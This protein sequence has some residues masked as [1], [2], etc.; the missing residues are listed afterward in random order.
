ML[1]LKLD[2]PHLQLS[3]VAIKILRRYFLGT[4][5]GCVHV[6]EGEL[7]RLKSLPPSQC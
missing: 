4:G 6:V 1:F 3:G 7:Q 5:L 2:E